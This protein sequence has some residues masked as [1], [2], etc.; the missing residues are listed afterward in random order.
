MINNL[1]IVTTPFD[2]LDTKSLKVLDILL[3]NRTFTNYTQTTTSSSNT[4]ELTLL[5]EVVLIVEL[6]VRLEALYYDRLV[7]LINTVKQY[8]IEKIIHELQQLII[9]EKNHELYKDA[10]K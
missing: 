6:G 10:T 4:W 5:D 2:V 3:H 1:P 7:D 9:Q 8:H